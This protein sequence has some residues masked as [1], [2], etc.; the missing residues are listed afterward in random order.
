METS[1]PFDET[2]KLMPPLTIEDAVLKD[3]LTISGQE[4]SRLSEKVRGDMK[5]EINV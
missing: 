1:G 4:L 3:G 2:V 5:Q